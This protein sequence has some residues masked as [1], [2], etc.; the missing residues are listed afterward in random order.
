MGNPWRLGVRKN[1]GSSHLL[2]AGFRET[3]GSKARMMGDALQWR[4]RYNFVP[5]RCF[6]NGSMW[7]LRRIFRGRRGISPLVRAKTTIIINISE[8]STALIPHRLPRIWRGI[9]EP[10]MMLQTTL[11]NPVAQPGECASHARGDIQKIF[12]M[13]RL[14]RNSATQV[15]IFGMLPI[16]TANVF[17][18]SATNPLPSILASPHSSTTQT[19][20]KP[21]TRQQGCRY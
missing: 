9:H 15:H 13:H 14:Q 18:N 6:D 10:A 3:S 2:N 12:A 4:L 5:R 1:R 20:R 19:S 8:Y 17:T 21:P 7:K 11:H 16:R